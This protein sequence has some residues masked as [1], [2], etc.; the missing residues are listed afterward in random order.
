[1]KLVRTKLSRHRTDGRSLARADCEKDFV[2]VET[3]EPL[4]GGFLATNHR[5]MLRQIIAGCLTLHISFG[6]G[7]RDD[8]DDRIARMLD[9]ALE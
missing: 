8:D 7:R 9:E 4:G 3:F 6:T 2:R 5:A 1:M